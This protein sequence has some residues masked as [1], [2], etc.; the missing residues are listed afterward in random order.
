MEQRKF[1]RV[2]VEYSASF[3]GASYRAQ[4]T[5][6]N[7]STIGCRA[8]TG[9]VVK[10]DDRLGVLID[11]PTYERPLYIA[12]AEVRWSDGQEFGME[13]IHMEL[14]DQQRLCE[15]IRT[16]EAAPDRRAEHGDEGTPP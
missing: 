7:L 14:E 6:L 10:K 5:V 15:T 4:G 8:R 3:S 13:F 11:V 1:D 12:R 2:R 16:I 9:F